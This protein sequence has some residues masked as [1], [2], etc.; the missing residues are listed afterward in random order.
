[1]KKK[2]F[3]LQSIQCNQLN[4][5]KW[6][7]VSYLYTQKETKIFLINFPIKNI[8]FTKE[9]KEEIQ[10]EINVIFSSFSD[11]F[12]CK[13]NI[14][15]NDKKNS[16]KDKILIIQIVRLLIIINTTFNYQID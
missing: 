8:S 9:R 13:E 14:S 10:P 6:K 11:F 5:K 2:K 4:I 16:F 1:M 12:F 15:L 3:F 7:D